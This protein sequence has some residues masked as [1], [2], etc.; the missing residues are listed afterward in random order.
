MQADDGRQISQT[1]RSWPL[2]S[3]ICA[4]GLNFSVFSRE[5]LGV[6][7]LFFDPEDDAPPACVSR[8]EPGPR[9]TSQQG[10]L[11]WRR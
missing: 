7:L 11:R 4:G 1:G 9:T 10:S 8:I 5:S 6:E 3:S 2:G